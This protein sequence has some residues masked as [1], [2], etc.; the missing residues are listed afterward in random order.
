MVFLDTHAFILFHQGNRNFLSESAIR[1]FDEAESLF[2]SPIVLLETQY[3]AEIGRIRY[4]ADTIFEQMSAA[5]GVRIEEDQYVQ[6]T[7]KA[8]S[9]SWTRDP[10]D[11]II[12][13]HASLFGAVLLTKDATIRL[14]Y[15]RAVW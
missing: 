10:F 7:R 9:F 15:P 8:I 2:I 6:A 11:R 4:G 14:N 3:L 1:I 13:A 12:T 5:F